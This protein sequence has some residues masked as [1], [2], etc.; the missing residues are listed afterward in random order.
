MTVRSLVVMKRV[1]FLGTALIVSIGA[2]TALLA[3]TGG[4]F[5]YVANSGSDNVSAYSIDATT[6]ALSTAAGSPFAARVNPV[7]VTTTAGPRPPAP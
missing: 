1:L 4:G 2:S 5:A 7:S 6:G 3:Q